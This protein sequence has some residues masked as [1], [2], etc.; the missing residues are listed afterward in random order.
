MH[1]YN[2]ARLTLLGS[3]E[4]IRI[5]Q[6]SGFGVFSAMESFPNNLRREYIVL[7]WDLDQEDEIEHNNSKDF[8]L[9]FMSRVANFDSVVAIPGKYFIII[10]HVAISIAESLVV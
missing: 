4:T 7:Q 1:R 10:F 5:V 6:N 2:F 8:F 9:G 3:F